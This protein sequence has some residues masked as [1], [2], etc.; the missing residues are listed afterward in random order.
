ME[1]RRRARAFL[2]VPFFGGWIATASAA[3][4]SGAPVH[5]VGSRPPGFDAAVRSAADRAVE[6]LAD[7]RCRGLLFEFH[8]SSGQP[9]SRRL[10]AADTTA[11]DFVESLVLVD[12]DR[13]QICQWTQV[14]AAT[15]PGSRV[16]HVCGRRFVR[17]HFLNPELA[18]AIVLHETL[19]ALGLSENPPS[20]AEITERVLARCRR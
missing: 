20:S 14:L 6:R 9:L 7:S 15:R 5:V 3:A 12:G 17:L 1:A 10:E 19:H 8:D 18:T 11:E 4:I 13:E 2:A 16:I